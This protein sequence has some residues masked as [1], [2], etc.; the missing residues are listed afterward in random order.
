M[1]FYARMAFRR[2]ATKFE[3]GEIT[4]DAYVARAARIAA[5]F[6]AANYQ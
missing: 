2:L 6:P 4:L 5:R 1:T 3:K